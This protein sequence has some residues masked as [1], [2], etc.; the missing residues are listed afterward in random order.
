MVLFPNSGPKKWIIIQMTI[1]CRTQDD[2]Q[3][4]RH[5]LIF[6]RSFKI[7]LYC[8]AIA[9]TTSFR[10]SLDFATKQFSMIIV[11]HD[12]LPNWLGLACVVLH[13]HWQTCPDIQLVLPSKRCAF[14]FRSIPTNIT[15][16]RQ[17][18]CRRH[19]LRI[20]HTTK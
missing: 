17:L 6:W 4:K 11:Q 7:L 10:K 20:T 3:L 13:M 9:R 2:D 12:T 5:F 16:F 15:A 1:F 18:E 14:Y 19:A 8:L